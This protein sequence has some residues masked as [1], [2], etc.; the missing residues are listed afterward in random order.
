MHIT[1]DH[2]DLLAGYFSGG[3]HRGV[4]GRRS[5]NNAEM[6]MYGSFA[7]SFIYSTCKWSGESAGSRLDQPNQLS[8]FRT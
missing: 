6:I 7:Y 3:G 4:R 5:I 8:F 1:A 2:F